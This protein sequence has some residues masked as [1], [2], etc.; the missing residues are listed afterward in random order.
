MNMNK[1]YF[2]NMLFV[3]TKIFIDNKKL[4]IFGTGYETMQRF[5]LS[6]TDFDYALRLFVGCVDSWLDTSG[7]R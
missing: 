2:W 5:D 1:I 3:V 7:I 4:A 6:T